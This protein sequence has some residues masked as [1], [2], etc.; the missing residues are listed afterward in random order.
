MCHG[1]VRRAIGISS[2]A[3]LKCKLSRI[4]AHR[5]VA[6]ETVIFLLISR[7]I[8]QC[9]AKIELEVLPSEVKPACLSIKQAGIL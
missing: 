8:C 7:I 1:A 2:N 4:T 9:T 6:H 3:F 5:A